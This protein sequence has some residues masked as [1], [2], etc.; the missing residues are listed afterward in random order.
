MLKAGERWGVLTHGMLSSNLGISGSVFGAVRISPDAELFMGGGGRAQGNYKDAN[1]NAIPNTFSDIGTATVKA[2]FRPAEGHQVKLGFIDYDATYNTGQPFP[3][4]TP[5]PLASIYATRT[6][7]Q[8]AN[9][10]WTYSRPDD[11]VFDFD[12]NIYWTRTSADQTKI[13]GTP[14]VD[15]GFIGD[16][17]NFTIN[18]YGVDVH[19]TS[20]FDI[21]P[22]RNA[23]TYGAD[24]F[25]DQVGTVGFNTV[26][27]PSGERTVS[28]G[29]V[30]VK[31]NYE[32]L[33]EVIGALRYDR[34]SWRAVA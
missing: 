9:G 17:R 31:S 32:T 12:G 19:N 15:T 4:G 2:T 3:A 28:G 16:R 21:G 25:Q 1:G 5:P 33:L 18:T 34:Y 6:Q 10:R 20:R 11:R 7:N 8:I 24:S 13:G 26:F 23:I 29:F 22:I 30:Q 14:A 27:T